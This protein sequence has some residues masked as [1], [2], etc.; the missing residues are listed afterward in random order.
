MTD[1]IKGALGMA[2]LVG[3]SVGVFW[4]DLAWYGAAVGGVLGAL[5]MRFAP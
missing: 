5:L 2:A 1:M 4:P 3:A